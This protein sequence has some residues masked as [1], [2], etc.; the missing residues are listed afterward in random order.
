MMTFCRFEYDGELNPAFK[1]GP[2]SLPVGS[3]KAVLKEPAAPRIVH[4]SSAGD[5]ARPEFRFFSMT[6]MFDEVL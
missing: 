3:I 6:Y 4:V 5:F 2:F 1:D